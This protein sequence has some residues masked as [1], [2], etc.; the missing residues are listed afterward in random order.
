VVVQDW[1]VEAWLQVQVLWGD[2][3]DLQVVAVFVL[4]DELGQRGCVDAA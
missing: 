4:L 2:E 3:R 1:E